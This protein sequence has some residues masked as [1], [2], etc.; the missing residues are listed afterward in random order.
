MRCTVAGCRL[1]PSPILSTLAAAS[2]PASTPWAQTD[3]ASYCHR[4][5]NTAFQVAEAKLA[6]AEERADTVCFCTFR[7]L[8]LRFPTRCA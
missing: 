2:C 7:N 5:A 4:N 6:E 1:L 3:H 8:T